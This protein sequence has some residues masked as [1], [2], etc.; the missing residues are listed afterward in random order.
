[1]ILQKHMTCS[2]FKGGVNVTAKRE[3]TIVQIYIKITV[4][5]KSKS[6]IFSLFF[7]YNKI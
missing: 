6:N 2:A 4:E 5:S 3:M 1:M 7:V